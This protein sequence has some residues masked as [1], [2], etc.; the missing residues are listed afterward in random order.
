MNNPVSV[1]FF[2]PDFLAHGK[3]VVVLIANKQSEF[4]HDVAEIEAEGSPH[5]SLRG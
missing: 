4:I 3:D 2:F 1:S 5:K